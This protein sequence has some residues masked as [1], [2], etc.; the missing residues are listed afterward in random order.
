MLV[1]PHVGIGYSEFLDVNE[2]YRPGIRTQIAVGD[3]DGDGKLDLLVG[4]FCTYIRPRA[5]LK[6]EEKKRVAEIR[7]RIVDFHVRAPPFLFYYAGCR[8]SQLLEETWQI[9]SS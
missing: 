2:D 7:V 1:K 9:W 5:D 3:W 6:P 4:D 8:L